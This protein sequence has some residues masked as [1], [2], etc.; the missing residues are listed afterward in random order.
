MTPGAKTNVELQLLAFEGSGVTVGGG[1]GEHWP[2]PTGRLQS[3]CSEAVQL[4]LLQELNGALG[5]LSIPTLSIP[6][7]A[8]PVDQ[9]RFTLS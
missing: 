5:L 8:E 3:G 1:G 6:T 4:R 9:S 7:H 2:R